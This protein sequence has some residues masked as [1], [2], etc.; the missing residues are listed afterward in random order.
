MPKRGF[1]RQILLHCHLSIQLWT[2]KRRSFLK[3]HSARKFRRR[4]L[5]L[6]SV[7]C[8]K[9]IRTA[10]LNLQKREG[11]RTLL[12]F[13]LP[14]LI[15][16]LPTEKKVGRDTIKQKTSLLGLLDLG[17]CRVYDFPL[18]SLSAV[19]ALNIYFY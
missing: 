9:P 17:Y 15:S 14:F 5:S 12:F 3:S 19:A 1:F 4:R 2:K 16:P 6:A 11:K 13:A 7:A 18:Q 8:R 10:E